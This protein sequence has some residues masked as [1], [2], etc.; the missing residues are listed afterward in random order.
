MNEELGRAR[1]GLLRN[2]HGGD[3]GS[4]L[5]ATVRTMQQVSRIHAGLSTSVQTSCPPASL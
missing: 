1:M 5:D 2:T 4:S 3:L